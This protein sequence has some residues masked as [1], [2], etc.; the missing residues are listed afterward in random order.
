MASWEVPQ[1]INYGGDYIEVKAPKSVLQPFYYDTKWK[2]EEAF[3]KF[4]ENSDTVKWWFKNGDRDSVYFAVPYIE[5]KE[6]NPFYVD[7]IVCFAD[8]SI[9]LY[10]TKSGRT[11]K[12]AREKSDG[13]QLFIKEH[14]SSN[15]KIIGG[16]VSNTDSTNFKGRWMVYKA[17]SSELN[18]D[19]FSNW[20]LLEI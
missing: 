14:S 8:G 19:D 2:T 1:I 7:F 20:E 3:I 10:D 16:I 18:P 13:L 5:N 6:Q 9:G 12:D 17:E 15:P 4:L 11:I